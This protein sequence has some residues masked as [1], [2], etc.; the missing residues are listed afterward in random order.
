MWKRYD[1]WP[2][3]FLRSHIL[4]LPTHDLQ[5][6]H[7]HRSKVSIPLKL[8]ILF[9]LMKLV[10]TNWVYSGS[11]W[12]FPL[13]TILNFGKSSPTS[14]MTA[15]HGCT[16][17]LEFLL[18]CPPIGQIN[19]PIHNDVHLGNKFAKLINNGHLCFFA[20]WPFFHREGW[21]TKVLWFHEN[22]LRV[23]PT[24]FCHR[25]GMED[26]YGGLLNFYLIE[27]LQCL[28]ELPNQWFYVREHIRPVEWHSSVGI[29]EVLGLIF[30]KKLLLFVLDVIKGGA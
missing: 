25:D 22:N 4:S 19:L 21:R 6:L 16:H 11:V 9:T 3:P 10:N 7:H 2:S 5:V 27:T 13:F 18:E 26:V 29:N 23:N 8:T 30:F 14:L 12:F 15:S 20:M 1:P 17:K 28:E 24:P